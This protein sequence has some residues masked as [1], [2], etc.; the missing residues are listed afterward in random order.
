MPVNPPFLGIAKIDKR[1]L[2]QA[3]GV[4]SQGKGRFIRV[5]G[6]MKTNYFLASVLTSICVVSSSG[7]ASANGCPATS[8]NPLGHA[9]ACLDIT[10]NSNTVT[11]TNPTSGSALFDATT[12]D[13]T[14]I[15]VRNNS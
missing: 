13:D 10:L 3:A 6:A 4:L 14:L 5:E 11:I 8:S 9:T 7:L 1:G 2:C 15:L 12:L